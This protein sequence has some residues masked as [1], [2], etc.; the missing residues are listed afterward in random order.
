M[1]LPQ[2]TR[3]WETSRSKC[4][5]SLTAD[6]LSSAFAR[7]TVGYRDSFFRCG[8]AATWRVVLGTRIFS[9]I[10]RFR[11]SRGEGACLVLEVGV[12]LKLLSRPTTARP[13]DF[14][15]GAPPDVGVAGSSGLRLRRHGGEGASSERPRL[16]LMRSLPFR[17]RGL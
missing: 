15:C 4:Y 5:A 9:S 16:L 14:S 2:R 10:F 7:Q 3:P 17:D 6:E 12:T 11:F 8:R 1:S 13:S